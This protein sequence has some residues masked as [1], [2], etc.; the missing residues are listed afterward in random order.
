[1]VDL[2]EIIRANP[3]AAK[4]FE[5]IKATLETLKGLRDAGVIK[6]SETFPHAKR[7]TLIGLKPRGSNRQK[8]YMALRGN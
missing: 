7:P 5:T 3:N 2:N 4:E 6:S 1:M 8:L